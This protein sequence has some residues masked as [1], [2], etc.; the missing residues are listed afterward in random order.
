MAGNRGRYPPEYKEQIVELVRSGRSPGSLA[1]EFE[2]SE[3]TIWNWV[4]QAD[5]DEGRRSDGLTPE[6]RLELL[7]LQRE[8]SPR[9]GGSV[10]TPR[11][12][13]APPSLNPPPCAPNPNPRTL[14][15]EPAAQ[16]PSDEAARHRGC[17]RAFAPA[18]PDPRGR[19][20]ARRILV[21]EPAGHVLPSRFR[22]DGAL[23]EPA[24]DNLD[25][26]PSELLAM[27][28]EPDASTARSSKSIS[29]SRGGRPG[30]RPSRRCRRTW[31]RI[32]RPTTSADRTAAAAWRGARPTKAGIIRKRTRQP[33][34][35]KEVKKAA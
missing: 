8:V 29:A 35:R 16:L 21:P 10:R 1:R 28:G 14:P 25:D 7:R 12:Q 2:P 3:Q 19:S 5:M 4:K 18:L 6:T 11:R 20:R 22:S 24:T 34:A 31:M 23:G 27:V 9:E 13:P 32:L 30:T 15:E 26:I 33:S 17:G